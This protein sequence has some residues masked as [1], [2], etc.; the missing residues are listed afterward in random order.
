M[1]SLTGDEKMA[2]NVSRRILTNAKDA[3]HV[4]SQDRSAVMAGMIPSVVELSRGTQFRQSDVE[5]ELVKSQIVSAEDVAH[6]AR[7]M[8]SPDLMRVACDTA[9]R[10][11]D[12]APHVMTQVLE[13]WEGPLSEEIATTIRQSMAQQEKHGLRQ[14]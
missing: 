12:A 9:T 5:F 3:T 13:Q 4:P 10:A 2:L 11:V 1:K 8:N 7:S 6:L 14:H